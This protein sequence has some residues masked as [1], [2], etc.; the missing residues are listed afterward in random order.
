MVLP[1]WPA[2]SVWRRAPRRQVCTCRDTC[3]VAVRSM[4]GGDR[5]I[6]GVGVGGQGGDCGVGVCVV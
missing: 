4:R 6:T 1:G 5:F 2:D 3:V